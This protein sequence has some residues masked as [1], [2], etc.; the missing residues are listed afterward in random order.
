MVSSPGNNHLTAAASVIAQ[1]AGNQMLVMKLNK[2]ASLHASNADS[3][4]ID[5]ESFYNQQ[6]N[7]IREAAKNLDLVK[8][9]LS[10][11]V[12]LKKTAVKTKMGRWSPAKSWKACPIGMLPSDVGSSG[13]VPVLDDDKE[14][15]VDEKV[16]VVSCGSKREADD[17]L[18]NSDAKKLKESRFIDEV[19]EDEDRL[20]KNGLMIGGV[21]KRVSEDEVINMASAVRILV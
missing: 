13:L 6:E 12:K 5:S 21:W 8:R 7:S 17:V 4:T 10:E 19:E 16:E 20:L 3:V 2:L 1:R 14:H 18:E 15:E 9:K 11:K